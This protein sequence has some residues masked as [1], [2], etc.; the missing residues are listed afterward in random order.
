[1]RV[2]NMLDPILAGRLLGWRSVRKSIRLEF[3]KKLTVG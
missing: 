1:M 3:E 2:D